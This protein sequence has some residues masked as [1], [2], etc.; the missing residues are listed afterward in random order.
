MKCVNSLKNWTFP[1]EF[2]LLAYGGKRDLAV[3]KKSPLWE[4][5]A[6]S[7]TKALKHFSKK[8][9]EKFWRQ[10]SQTAAFMLSSERL[11][12]R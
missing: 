7:L 12:A 5:K 10:S 1:N 4:K 8:D 9:D 11:K 2:D 6:N 3:M